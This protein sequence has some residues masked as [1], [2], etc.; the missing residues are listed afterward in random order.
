[1]A[2]Q[3]RANAWAGAPCGG[4]VFSASSINS[5]LADTNR[6]NTR[7]SGR[8][9]VAIEAASVYRAI[10]DRPSPQRLHVHIVDKGKPMTVQVK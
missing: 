1:V 7:L 8:E 5:V 2:G 6:G 10:P 9:R 4:S 3:P